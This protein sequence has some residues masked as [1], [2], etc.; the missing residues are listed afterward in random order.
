MEGEVAGR[1]LSRTSSLPA[2]RRFLMPNSGRS[3]KVAFAAPKCA[4]TPSACT[5]ATPMSSLTTPSSSCVLSPPSA[6]S[7]IVLSGRWTKGGLIG[8][9]GFGAVYKA[10]DSDTLEMFAVKEAKLDQ[11]SAREKLDTELKLCQSLRHPNIISYLGHK[12]TDQCLY[13]FLEIADGG[14]IASMLSEFGP[15]QG[16]ALT[17][18]T[19]GILEGLDY[20]HTRDVPVVHRDV[21][22]ANVLVTKPFNVKLTDFGNSKCDVDTKSWNQGGSVP[23]MAPEVIHQQEG[24]GRKADIWSFGCTVIEMVTAQKPWGNQVFNCLMHAMNHIGFS[25]ETPPVPQA[26]PSNLQNLIRACTQH[27]PEQRPHAEELLEQHIGGAS[28]RVDVRSSAAGHWSRARLQD[29]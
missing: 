14:S 2:L 21:K 10:M 28:R 1:Q 13:I 7:P 19:S 22:G 23:W 16:P 20:L 15:F 9:G 8:H 12:F 6:A 29:I 4:D 5:T 18:A 11:G 3:Q 25:G 26:A 27:S 24:H 17:K